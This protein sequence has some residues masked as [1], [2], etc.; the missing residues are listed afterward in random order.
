M[1]RPFTSLGWQALLIVRRTKLAR[2]A[3]G[4]KEAAPGLSSTPHPAGG[5]Q[6]ALEMTAPAEDGIEGPG[7]KPRKFPRRGATTRGG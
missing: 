2:D 6:Q 5:L 4:N 7:P 3:R 1:E